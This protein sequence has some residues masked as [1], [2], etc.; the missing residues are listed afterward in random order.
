MCVNQTHLGKSTKT[1]LIIF[2]T[3]TLLRSNKSPYWG[4]TNDL[5]KR[6]ENTLIMNKC[7]RTPFLNQVRWVPES[8]KHTH[9]QFKLWI[10][11]EG[12]SPFLRLTKTFLNK[13]QTRFLNK[14]FF[15][16]NLGTV[17]GWFR[18]L[19]EVAFFVV[20]GV[21]LKEVERRSRGVSMGRQGQPCRARGVATICTRCFQERLTTKCPKSL[22]SWLSDPR[23]TFL[24]KNR[25]LRV[26]G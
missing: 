12:T 16:L 10:M 18:F 23:A 17:L 6:P 3:N 2:K 14:S 11:W 19:G 25:A 13:V 7:C 26:T 1:H 20:S 8:L 24:N 21:V 22:F 4:P 9:L 15:G 5:I